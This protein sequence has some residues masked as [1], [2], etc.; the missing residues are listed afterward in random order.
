VL[1]ALL[2]PTVTEQVLVWVVVVVFVPVAGPALP[3]QDL[4]VTSAQGVSV[5][6]CVSLPDLASRKQA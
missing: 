2:Q 1:V 3:Q 6:C 4:F 5:T